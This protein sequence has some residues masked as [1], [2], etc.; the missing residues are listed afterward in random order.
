VGLPKTYRLKHRRDFQLVYQ[1]GIRL[2]SPHLILRAFSPVDLDNS[3]QLPPT[4][5]GISI[6]R[7]VSKK[8]VTRNRIKRQ[9]RLAIREMLSLLKPGWKVVIVVKF[10]ASECKCE[11]FLRELKKLLTQAKIINGH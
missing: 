4:Q 3:C 1:K 6:G 5:F 10:G 11:H 7:K 8:A 2:N 9:I